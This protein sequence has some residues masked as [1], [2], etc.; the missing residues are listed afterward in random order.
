MSITVGNSEAV[1]AAQG[2]TATAHGVKTA[3]LAKG[4]QELE[5][6]MAMDLIASATSALQTIAPP[7]ASSGNNINIKV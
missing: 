2:N 4:Q 5:G 1:Q 7:T 3:Q 6:Q